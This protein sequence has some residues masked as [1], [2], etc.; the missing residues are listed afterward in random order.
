[1]PWIV[2]HRPKLRLIFIYLG[3]QS[4]IDSF[5]WYVESTLELD[6]E[7]VNTPMGPSGPYSKLIYLVGMCYEDHIKFKFTFVHKVIL[8]I[9]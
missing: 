5:Q 1:M 4:T 6:F 7:G 9:T 2:C 8:V 3:Y